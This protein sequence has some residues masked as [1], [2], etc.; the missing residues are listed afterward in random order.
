M[1]RTR[2][3]RVFLSSGFFMRWRSTNLRDLTPPVYLIRLTLILQIWSQQPPSCGFLSSVEDSD[4]LRLCFALKAF[5]SRC[6]SFVFQDDVSCRTSENVTERLVVRLR[7]YRTVGETTTMDSNQRKHFVG[8]VFVTEKS[9][10]VC[11]NYFLS[12]DLIAHKKK[13]T[14]GVN[15]DFSETTMTGHICGKC[16]G[17]QMKYRL[18][19]SGSSIFVEYITAS[20]RRVSTLWK[21]S[22]FSDV[23]SGPA[24]L[25]RPRLLPGWHVRRV[26]CRW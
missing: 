21:S 17:D 26:C 10:Y 25:T 9:T 20:P 13:N 5:V 8:F 7:L 11:R 15:V 1:F 24:R 6:F 22:D 18:I 4:V 23:S 19:K 3:R 12:G 14:R 16:C 2:C